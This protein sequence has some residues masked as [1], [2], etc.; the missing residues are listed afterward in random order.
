M[1]KTILLFLFIAGPVFAQLPLGTVRNP[2]YSDNSGNV[3]STPLT[4]SNNVTQAA[5][6][7]SPGHI[8]RLVD[9]TNSAAVLAAI[10]NTTDSVPWLDLTT[11]AKVG[12]LSTNSTKISLGT[13]SD[14]NAGS[15]TNFPGDIVLTNSQVFLDAVT[16]ITGNLDITAIRT[17]RTYALSFSNGTGYVTQTI[18]NGLATS[19]ITNGLATIAY[20]DGA[21]NGI[22]AITNGLVNSSITNGLAS[23]T[24]AT[25]ITNGLATPAVTNGL[26]TASV[27]NGLAGSSVNLTAGLGLTGGGNLT[28][29]RT[30]AINPAIV[31]TN[32]MNISVG[33]V[34]G[35]STPNILTNLLETVPWLSITGTGGNSYTIAT[36]ALIS[37]AGS[38]DNNG[39]SI[40]NVSLTAG[41]SGILPV[42][43]GGTG[44]SSIDQIK[45]L[46]AQTVL[47]SNINATANL[48]TNL[49]L[50]TSA[51]TNGNV[52]VN[53]SALLVLD[54]NANPTLVGLK[55]LKIS[56]SITNVL[57]ENHY[58]ITGA[59]GSSSAG[60]ISAFDTLSG[61]NAQYILQGKCNTGDLDD[62]WSSFSPNVGDTTYTSTNATKIIINQSPP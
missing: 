33:T 57:S 56:N 4:F 15:L 49:V 2:V 7:S 13:Y 58:T 26:V 18:T 62:L 21:T 43:N 36:N 14:N 47:A 30:F 44:V 50:I 40:T 29:D 5:T 39:T 46:S 54:N 9:I 20:V 3:L 41:V 32:G 48:Y 1:K 28:A 35:L 31:L 17:G 55:L 6:P 8:A 12:T 61:F 22:A 19:G 23:L 25:A 60:S 27:T 42:A 52:T 51:R 11:A 53:A 10:T 24:Y 16:N 45:S 59:A 38:T 37:I 34:N